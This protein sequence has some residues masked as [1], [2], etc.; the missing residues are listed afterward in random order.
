MS[1]PKTVKDVLTEAV[2]RD[3]GLALTADQLNFDTPELINPEVVDFNSALRNSH[4]RIWRAADKDGPA[5]EL[6]IDYNRLQLL[7]LASFR[8]LQ[9]PYTG[10]ATTLDLL[11][12][13]NARFGVTLTAED[14]VSEPVIAAGDES[15]TAQLRAAPASLMIFG[16]LELSLGQ[17]QVP[18]EPEEPEEPGEPGGP[19]DFARDSAMPVDLFLSMW[20]SEEDDDIYLVGGIQDHYLAYLSADLNFGAKMEHATLPVVPTV[21]AGG[22]ETYYVEADEYGDTSTSMSVGMNFGSYVGALDE[23]YEVRV[24]HTLLTPE[25]EP[26]SVSYKLE[27]IEIPNALANPGTHSIDAAFGPYDPETHSYDLDI[28]DDSISEVTF[29]SLVSNGGGLG[30]H[31]SLH[32]QL[33]VIEGGNDDTRV[34][35]TLLIDGEEVA[36]YY[37]GD[38]GPQGNWEIITPND[39]VGY[40]D[41]EFR[42]SDL[43]KNVGVKLR[44]TLKPQAIAQYELSDLVGT[45]SAD[46]IAYHIETTAQ[47]R[48]TGVGFD[49]FNFATIVDPNRALPHDGNGFIYGDYDTQIAVTH[50]QTNDTTIMNLRTVVDGGLEEVADRFTQFSVGD[51]V[52]GPF[53]EDG[54]LRLV[55][56]DSLPPGNSWC[57]AWSD[58]QAFSGCFSNFSTHSVGWS[59]ADFPHQTGV[60]LGVQVDE[61]GWQ[62]LIAHEDLTQYAPTLGITVDNSLEIELIELLPL[63]QDFDWVYRHGE[64]ARFSITR[65]HPTDPVVL[66]LQGSGQSWTLGPSHVWVDPSGYS[67]LVRLTNEHFLAAFPHKTNSQ[68]LVH[69]EFRIVARRFVGGQLQAKF[70]F[71][72]RPWAEPELIFETS[73]D[74][75]LGAPFSNDGT[76]YLDQETEDRNFIKAESEYLTVGLRP[77]TSGNSVDPDGNNDNPG[78]G[79]YEISP[80]LID[81]SSGE[82]LLHFALAHSANA[83]IIDDFDITLNIGAGNEYYY[84]SMHLQQD[85]DFILTG[86]GLAEPIRAG[87]TGGFGEQAQFVVNLTALAVQLGWTGA[88]PEHVVNGSGTLLGTY[89]VDVGVY[90]R[91]EG[92]TAYIPMTIHVPGNGGGDE[93]E[94]IVGSG[95]F[96]S[97]PM[98]AARTADFSRFA[99]V[100]DSSA[101]KIGPTDIATHVT[102]VE[103]ELIILRASGWPERIEVCVSQNG[104][105][106][107]ETYQVH[108]RFRDLS[109]STRAAYFKGG[110]YIQLSEDLD[111]NL[112]GSGRAYGLFRLVREEV[113]EVVGYTFERV[114]DIPVNLSGAG[115]PNHTFADDTALYALGYKRMESN[116]AYRLT[117]FRTEDLQTWDEFDLGDTAGGTAVAT[118]ILDVTYGQG[119]VYLV[120]RNTRTGTGWDKMS[121]GVLDLTNIGAGIQWATDWPEIYEPV[122][123]SQYLVQFADILVT[124]THVVAATNRNIV[125]DTNGGGQYYPTN[126][127]GSIFAKRV[128]NLSAP[129]EV[130]NYDSGVENITL[131]YVENRLLAFGKRA[132]GRENG[133][134]MTYAFYDPDTGWSDWTVEEDENNVFNL[135]SDTSYVAAVDARSPDPYDPL[136]PLPLPPD[137]LLPNIFG[138]SEPLANAAPMMVEGPDHALYLATAT[139]AFTWVGSERVYGVYRLLPYTGEERENALDTSYL[140]RVS[141]S[142]STYQVPTFSSMTVDA[143]GRLYLASNNLLYAW[144]GSAYVGGKNVIRLL[145]NGLYDESFDISSLTHVRNC[146][147]NKRNRLMVWQSGTVGSGDVTVGDTT[148]NN[149]IELNLDGTVSEDFECGLVRQSAG[150][151]TGIQRLWQLSNGNYILYVGNNSTNGVNRK[152]VVLDEEGTALPATTMAY[153]GMTVKEVVEIAQEDGP[154]K[155]A[156]HGNN[157]NQNS[158]GSVLA[159]ADA[160]LQTVTYAP[161]AHEVLG[162]AMLFNG[163]IYPAALPGHFVAW[164]YNSTV[165]EKGQLELVNA[166]TFERTEYMHTAGSF[167]PQWAKIGP[168][169]DVLVLW[170]NSGGD[171]QW[172]YRDRFPLRHPRWMPNLT[173]A[174]QLATPAPGA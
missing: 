3:F 103:E 136:E 14:I 67:A 126:E 83:N 139:T 118:N 163:R 15:Y 17:A 35:Y 39:G 95:F 107:W 25:I 64:V 8:S 162:A 73:Y 89:E 54:V 161:Y 45:P 37:V 10:Q 146:M 46:Q 38:W 160:G 117:M 33:A 153:N 122:T 71:R 53:I 114:A 26:I 134:S 60:E 85:G 66:A 22:L 101:P 56:S 88:T 2:N 86:D 70:T 140:A 61:Q 69:G 57:R 102:G 142:G 74:Q 110:H 34:P 78:D 75:V 167:Q 16:E 68:G 77:W 97:N 119:K 12:Q 18:E 21:G 127:V 50:R 157:L 47:G 147:I 143:E 124:D 152:L 133:A 137:E 165:A 106:N 32:I 91:E 166:D 151:M 29:A 52:E 158:F 41:V 125:S 123:S 23:R 43:D 115:L 105:T 19:G 173:V 116:G 128:D 99:V 92:I 120:G 87:Y 59:S 84:I 28:T 155:V 174:L 44:L 104:G 150:T 36:S 138:T 30:P 51:T 1:N 93:P 98:M 79:T 159:V 148:P 170:T 13:F 172:I 171:A 90:K 20:S 6:E 94:E 63:S 82:L 130:L 164:T 168:N 108:R 121:Y 100:D 31:D 149:L 132:A 62:L 7:K 141:N 24:S 154:P 111:P 135:T 145:A 11:P 42:I 58:R 5:V 48:A 144:N 76:L 9:F 81:E 156:I 55:T 80:L 109:R 72:V 169:K 65:S 49:K 129:W 131:A 27:Y 40:G 112:S 113:D 4:V 96:V